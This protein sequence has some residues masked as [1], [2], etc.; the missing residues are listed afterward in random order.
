[1]VGDREEVADRA[2]VVAADAKL[3]LVLVLGARDIVYSVDG[4]VNVK[5]CIDIGIGRGLDR[6]YMQGGQGLY[7]GAVYPR[8]VNGR[9][10]E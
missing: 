6:L 8:K 4:D 3:A 10:L 2:G 1:L 9:S 5:G 7:R